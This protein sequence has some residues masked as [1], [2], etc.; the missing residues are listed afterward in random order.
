MDWREMAGRPTIRGMQGEDRWDAYYGA[1]SGGKQLGSGWEEGR[2]DG[3]TD[4][5]RGWVIAFSWMIA[6]F[7]EYVLDGLQ[8]LQGTD[9]TQH[10]LFM[11]SHSTTAL[12]LGFRAYTRIQP[13]RAHDLLFGFN[14]HLSVLLA[15]HFCMVSNNSDYC[16]A[17]LCEE[18]DG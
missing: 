15:R 4:P 2:W 8:C 9:N 1:W 7:A 18:R 13:P 14:T 12:H 16:G 17:T 10:I 3:W 6:S 11:Y 5:M